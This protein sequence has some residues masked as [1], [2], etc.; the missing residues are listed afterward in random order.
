MKKTKNVT[1][2]LYAALVVASIHVNAQSTFKNLG[3]ESA[4]VSGDTPGSLIPVANG[5][6]NWSVVEP[7][8]QVWYDNLALSSAMLAINDQNT[9][10]GFAPLQGNFSAYLAGG[11]GSAVAIMQTGLVPAGTKSLT[12]DVQTLSFDLQVTLGGQTISMVPLQTTSGY[13][14]YGGDIS[15]FSGNVEELAFTVP[16]TPN[17]LV[18]ATIDNIVFSPN[19]IP[20]PGAWSLLLCGAGLIGAVRFARSRFNVRPPS[21][22]QNSRH[23]L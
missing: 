10:F 5:F 4:N 6:P 23:L 9:G 21:G 16:N 20:E 15:S 11:E 7:L 14:V 1:L 2:T 3:F 8:T 19:S 22:R 18:S 17:S 12:V 13:T